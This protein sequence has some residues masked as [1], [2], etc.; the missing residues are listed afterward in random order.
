M[1]EPLQHPLGGR[2]IPRADVYVTPHE[3][4]ILVTLPG[5]TK[6]HLNLTIKNRQIEVA[7]L[8]EEPRAGARYLVKERLHGPFQRT[9]DVSSEFDINKA[10]ASFQNGT[11]KIIIPRSTASNLPVLHAQ[12]WIECPA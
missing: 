4:T 1:D 8:A 5:M 11:L 2:S 6:E 9:F 3:M 7:G 10:V 12:N